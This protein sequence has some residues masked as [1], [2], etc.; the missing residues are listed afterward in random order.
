MPSLYFTLVGG[1]PWGF[2]IQ[3]GRGTALPVR[4][5]RVNP[6]SK[7]AQ[8]GL[9]EGDILSMVNGHFT[10]G[11][12]QLDVQNV[13]RDAG[14]TLTLEV[15]REPM[16]KETT[17]KVYRTTQTLVLNESRSPQ[18]TD[19]SSPLQPH[20]QKESSPGSNT[21]NPSFKS[22][23]SS[24]NGENYIDHNGKDADK[25]GTQYNSHSQQE[26]LPAQDVRQHQVGNHTP[27]YSYAGQYNESPGYPNK[28]DTKY[29]SFSRTTILTDEPPPSSAVLVD[30]KVTVEGDQVHTDK[31][32][33]VPV[34]EVLKEKTSTAKFTPAPPKYDG[35]GPT[36]DGVPTG[37]RQSVKKE[38]MSNWY[39]TMFKSLHKAGHPHYGG[40]NSDPE[41]EREEKAV[42]TKCATLDTRQ[43]SNDSSR[44]PT[45]R[46]QHGYP[47]SAKS[48]V[49]VYNVHPRPIEDYEPGY[50][51]VVD[52][53]NTMV[54]KRFLPPLNHPK[55]AYEFKS[56]YES[57][58]SI[59]KKLNQ[60]EGPHPEQ[61]KMWYRE[62]QRGGDIP[63]YGLG[64]LA[65]EKPK[66]PVIGPAPQPSLQSSPVKPTYPQAVRPRTPPPESVVNDSSVTDVSNGNYSVQMQHAI[67]AELQRRMSPATQQSSVGY[68]SSPK[69]PSKSPDLKMFARVLYDFV[70][71]SPRELNLKKD[72]LVLVLRQ[73]DKNWY[74]GEHKGAV[75]I[76]PVSYVEILPPEHVSPQLKQPLEGLGKAVYDFRVQTSVELPLKKG[77]TVALIR[78]VDQ[79]WYEGRIN[80][81]KGIF[82]ASYIQVVQ[83][84]GESR[85]SSVSSTSKA[86]ESPHSLKVQ[87]DSVK[88]SPVAVPTPPPTTYSSSHTGTTTSSSPS[89][90][91]RGKKGSSL[92]EPVLYRA[93][94]GYSPQ[95]ADELQLSE[96]DNVY[97]VEMCDDGW[98]VGT[99]VR[100]GVFGIFP[101]NY[102]EKV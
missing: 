89:A 102:V 25:N 36:E 32:Y 79:N 98:F 6:E 92:V 43:K 80:D 61:Q 15:K 22:V 12:S 59:I 97:V 66:V 30:Q 64:K 85:R 18:N 81:K 46:L 51:S 75:G 26:P 24:T 96:G 100:T 86:V 34:K 60:P 50:S 2:R 69:S 45:S 19:V 29:P 38:N 90:F 16:S 101:G 5:S 9:M 47:V 39:K 10:D 35:I 3:G 93:L 74:D 78:R 44:Q 76:F 1:S 13:I 21:T 88:K 95:N 57:D 94:Y 11:M 58:T 91:G 72:E 23:W 73:L 67:H 4:I 33:A 65:P 14:H 56:G 83:E 17:E 8:Q 70:S 63:Q 87:E 27:N 82:P 42:I 62:I 40:Y 28:D 84:P 77:D 53:E 68:R 54:S 52:N 71:E 55:P 48:T 41:F 7:A 37:L 49:E 31:Y 99:S 20:A